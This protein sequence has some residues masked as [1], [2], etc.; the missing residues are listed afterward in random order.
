MGNFL[1]HQAPDAREVVCTAT[2]ADL[3]Q[4]HSALTH[5]QREQELLA[6]GAQAQTRAGA[7]PRSTHFR[8][9]PRPLA[10]SDFSDD[11]YII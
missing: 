2:N 11:D 8:R 3:P 1:L 9:A 10:V 6:F 5:H 4:Y 7:T